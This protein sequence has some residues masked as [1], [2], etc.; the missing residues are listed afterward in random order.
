MQTAA[1]PLRWLVD[2][3]A[4]IDVIVGIANAFDAQDWARVRSFLA[5]ELMTDYTQFRNEPAA[6]VRADAYVQERQRA[7]AGVRTLH[8]ST[9]HEVKVLGDQA[10]CTSAYR[11]YRF[12]PQLAPGENRFDTAGTYHHGLVR[13]AAGWLVCRIM[14]TVLLREGN[15][16]VHG[17]FIPE[18]LPQP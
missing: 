14:Q 13:T 12:N 15:P 11:I 8:V 4:I 16:L 9:N 6:R 2:R 1:E 10:E 7:L 3:A 17:A 5:E 18:R